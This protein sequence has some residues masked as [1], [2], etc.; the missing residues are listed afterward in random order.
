MNDRQHH[1]VVVG[2]GFGGLY[3]TLTLA[4]ARRQVRVT[5]I[6]RTNHHLFQPLL[7]QVAT[8][9]LSPANI[10]SPLRA[11]LR[12]QKN[13]T[14]LQAEVTG[15]DPAAPTVTLDD[16]STVAGDSL[17]VAAGARTNWFGNQG[18]WGPAAP[19]MKSLD[20]AL[21][22]RRQ[23]LG[24]FEHAE[25]CDD[26]AE[27]ERLLSFAVVGAGP[28]GVEMA[29]AIA[30]LA[31][32]TLRKEFR[33]F[34]PADVTVHL[35]EA[36]PAVL[37]T[38][39]GRLPD[40]ARRA[41]DRLGVTVRTETMIT[42]VDQRGVTITHDGT[43][44]RLPCAS[45]VWAAGVRG[46]ALGGAVADATD[47][48]LAR[49]DRV[50]VEPDCS[51]P[52]HAQV[53]VIGDL[54]H[55]PQ[56][57]EADDPAASVPLPGIAPVA[58]QQGR[59]VAKRILARLRGRDDH[60]PFRYLDKGMMATIGRNQAVMASGPIKASG[61]I[62]WLAWLLIHIMYLAGAQNR[63]M[64]LIQW[65]WAYLSRNRNARLI[66]GAALTDPD[67]VGPARS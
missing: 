19:G 43:T 42:E 6:D 14:V 52:E 7:Y 8:G 40:K 59:Y 51:L 10:A 66:T 20:D 57:P 3:A 55:Y 65:A 24:A 50:V 33:R 60:P 32:H 2:G 25:R 54:A 36:G 53:F 56:D 46:A 45:V 41:L 4:K 22:L 63:L 16:G 35:I 67:L 17:I 30:E 18:A 48:P 37:G 12:K 44:Q 26:A 31:H 13:V 23:I 21:Y 34:D 61:H 29:G 5:L 28:T 1:V 58:M 62:A 49:G 9:G 47:Q 39:P 64:V 38:F 15:V 27:R 11:L